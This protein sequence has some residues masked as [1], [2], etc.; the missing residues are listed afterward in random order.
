MKNI[1]LLFITLTLFL[2]AC[3]TEGKPIEPIE[4]S[5][6]EPNEKVE[7]KESTVETEKENFGEYL[8]TT[9]FYKESTS[10]TIDHIHGLGYI[11]NSEAVTVA[12][13]HGLFTFYQD[14]W[15]ETKT[16]KHDYMGFQ[17]VSDGFYASGHPEKGSTLKNPLGLVKSSNFGETLD[18]LTFYGETDF[19]YLAVG[20]DN[21]AVYAINQHSNSTIETGLYYSFDDGSTWDKSGVNGLPKASISNIATHPVDRDT[22]ALSTEAGVYLS[23]N[24]GNSFELVSDAQVVTSLFITSE[25]LFYSS[26][27]NNVNTLI[28]QSLESNDTMEIPTPMI[29]NGDFIIYIAVSPNNADEITVVTAN[30]SIFRTTNHGREWDQL[31]IKGEY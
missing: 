5:N 8:S 7:D 24:H 1:V 29:E 4:Q 3:S 13:H 17:A 11:A 21:H 15:Y 31:V 26:F 2:A 16:E 19:H 18:M 28:K 22:V 25:E 20:Y 23:K 6:E 12:S 27:V 10:E 14:K 30:S 9:D